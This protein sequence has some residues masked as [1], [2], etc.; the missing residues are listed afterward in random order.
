MYR[1]FYNLLESRC[2]LRL[3]SWLAVWN[4]GIVECW[5]P[6][7]RA[8]AAY[9]SERRLGMESGKRSILQKM[10]NLHFIMMHVRNPFSAF[11]LYVTHYYEKINPIIFVLILQTHHTIIPEPMIPIFQN[12]NIPEFH[13]SRIPSFQLGRSP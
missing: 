11:A 10:L 8:Y 5:P 3:F 4:N 12:S 7:R 2:F 1:N 9:A 6:A 13:H